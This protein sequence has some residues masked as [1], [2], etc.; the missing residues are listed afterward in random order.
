MAMWYVFGARYTENY[1]AEIDGFLHRLD[2]LGLLG[3]DEGNNL[4]EARAHG[5]PFFDITSIIRQENTSVMGGQMKTYG[6]EDEA[7]AAGEEA[8]SGH[9]YRELFEVLPEIWDQNHGFHIIDI[10]DPELV[11]HGEAYIHEQLTSY[12]AEPFREGS[13]VV[14]PPYI[15][16]YVE[17]NTVNGLAKGWHGGLPAVFIEPLRQ[18]LGFPYEWWGAPID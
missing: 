14:L 15:R 11:E 10:D 5:N 3:M 4:N 9:G 1:T 16:P 13:E 2:D 18:R 8:P 7:R 12:V 6:S 17:R